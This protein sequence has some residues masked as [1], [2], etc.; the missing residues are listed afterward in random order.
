M[1]RLFWTQNENPN[2][3][4]TLISTKGEI[5]TLDK[6]E[7]EGNELFNKLLDY[8]EASKTVYHSGNLFIKKYFE[9]GYFI[10]SN[11]SE[12]DDS[13]RRMGFMFFTQ[14]SKKED[15][16]NDLLFFSKLIQRNLT[17]QDKASISKELS[18]DINR[19]K[20]QIV[21]LIIAVIAILTIY[22]IWKNLN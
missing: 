6:Q 8:Q 18:E 16:I 14:N 17:D 19:K 12:K 7:N 3:P 21:K 5:I 4:N 20:K 11:F 13:N 15:V 22:V 9:G 1:V 2:I 10:S